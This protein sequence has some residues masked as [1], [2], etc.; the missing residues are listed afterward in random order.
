MYVH[1]LY[2]CDFRSL[3]V[4][5]VCIETLTPAFFS[6]FK[7]VQFRG[8]FTVHMY[9]CTVYTDM[10]TERSNQLIYICT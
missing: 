1:M 10:Y 2:Q 5:A 9:T 3:D 4:F 6:D 8:D 7:D